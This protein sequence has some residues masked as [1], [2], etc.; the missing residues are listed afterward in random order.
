MEDLGRAYQ[1][2]MAYDTRKEVADLKRRVESLEFFVKAL[3]V[4]LASA[5]CQMITWSDK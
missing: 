5:N 2:S 1:D 3:S 4:S